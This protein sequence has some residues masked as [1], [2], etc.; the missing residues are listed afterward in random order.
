M[1]ICISIKIPAYILIFLYAVSAGKK[2]NKQG[3]ITAVLDILVYFAALHLAWGVGIIKYMK[4]S[5]DHKE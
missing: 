3:K 2:E 1:T 5:R 4:G